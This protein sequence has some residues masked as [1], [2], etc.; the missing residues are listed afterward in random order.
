MAIGGG[1]GGSGV[2]QPAPMATRT[3]SPIPRLTTHRVLR[4]TP[5]VRDRHAAFGDL[6][7]LSIVLPP[8]LAGALRRL[9]TYDVDPRPAGVWRVSACHA[10]PRS[11]G[12]SPQVPFPVEDDADLVAELGGP[13]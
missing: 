8:R 7:R 5:S 6:S 10:V 4:I 11:R 9:P 12:A 1:S 2:A 3:S 13:S